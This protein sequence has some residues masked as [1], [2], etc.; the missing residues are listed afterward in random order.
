MKS[1]LLSLVSLFFFVFCSIALS[2][3]LI[4]DLFRDTEQKEG[5]IKVPYTI[6]YIAN[7][8]RKKF[9]VPLSYGLEAKMKIFDGFEL[10]K[11]DK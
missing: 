5:T 1:S 11:E 8:K 10:T 7:K 9:K 2:L 4:G 3:I 6:N